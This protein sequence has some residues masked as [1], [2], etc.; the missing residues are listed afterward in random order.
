MKVLEFWKIIALFD[1]SQEGDDEAVMRPAIDALIALGREEILAFEEILAKKLYLLD[2]KK[3]A[4]ACYRG[5]LAQLSVDDFLYSRC[6]VVANGKEFF[7]EV[8][9]NPGHMP[10]N[11]EFEALLS[12]AEIAYEEILG[13]QLSEILTTE[14]SYETY[15]NSAGWE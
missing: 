13:D 6:V 15:A 1:W 12:L 3:H 9:Y 5:D 8:R 2:T 7:D 4:L 11:L 10:Q 14:Y